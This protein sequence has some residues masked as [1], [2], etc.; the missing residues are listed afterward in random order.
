[1]TTTTAGPPPADDLDRLLVQ[2]VDGLAAQ[3]PLELAQGAALDRARVILA[4]AERLRVLGLRAISDIEVRGL[5]ALE[6]ASSTSAWVAAQQVVGLDRA[7]VGLARRLARVPLVGRQLLA[8]SLSAQAGMLIAR[9]V[10][11]ARPFLD[12][13]DGLIDGLAA[14]PVLFGVLVDGVSSLLAEQTGGAPES[15]P[16]LC[17]LRAELEATT[18]AGTSQLA[19]WEAGLVLF[20]RRCQAGQLRSGLE[21]LLDAL[22][23]AE[24]DKRAARAD[25]DAGIGLQHKPGGSGW[26]LEGDLDDELGEILSVVMVAEQAVDPDN[27]A[28]TAAWSAA[29]ERPDLAGLDPQ[30]W[31]QAMARPRSR[32]A[33]QHDALKAGL[34]RLL[35]SGALG[36]RDKARPHIAVTVELDFV[37]GVP[38]ALPARTMS[39]GRLSRR[40]IRSLLCQGSFTRLVLDAGRRVIGA[41]H[42]AR[43]A[44]ALERLVVHA[45]WGGLCAGA[46]CTRGPA[47]GHP[48]TPHHGA[49][50]STTGVTALDDTIPLCDGEHHLLQADGQVIR[51]KDGRWIGPDG[52]IQRDRQ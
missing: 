47:T 5:H 24:H 12:R 33:A 52:W 4:Q 38:G 50:Y 8:G 29:G 14:E 43:T 34:R 11:R 45:Q 46:G 40:Q 35:D 18:A 13:P 21:L 20:G 39:G 25:Q 7:Q 32:R 36:Q 49:L 28:D 9:A 42:T 16:D 26:L 23:P 27:P 48:L 3:P 10:E 37:Q 22:L 41:S 30:H 15:D 17:G 44:T 6:G 1:M 51:L 31:P 19:R 2:V